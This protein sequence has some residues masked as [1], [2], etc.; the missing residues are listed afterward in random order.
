M[1][2]GAGRLQLRTGESF[3]VRPGD[4]VVVTPGTVHRYGGVNGKCFVED[5][6]N[7]CGPVADMLAASGVI[8]NGVFPFDRVRRLLPVIERAA[9]PSV[10]SQIMANIELQKILV[11]LYLNRKQTM[12]FEYPLV[13]GLLLAIREDP[14][15]WWTVKEMAEMCNLS[16]D[17]LRRVF[18]ARTG[19]APKIYVDRLKLFRAAEFLAETGVSVSAAAERFGYRDPYHFSRRFKDV[20]GMP[21]GR[22]RALF[23]VR[24]KDA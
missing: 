24:D 6:V 3:E 8:A 12:N 1:Y 21:P 9:D 19:F 10:D 4:C 16:E 7:F 11:E 22:Y 23:S 2:E 5:S 20:T 14:R 13:E 15:R 17:Q 18:L